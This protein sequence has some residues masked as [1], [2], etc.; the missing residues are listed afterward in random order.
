MCEFVA[1][2]D[3]LA[4]RGGRR[5]ALKRWIPTKADL[6]NWFGADHR[7]VAALWPQVRFLVALRDAESMA[8]QLDILAELKAMTSIWLSTRQ[9]FKTL[10]QHIAAQRQWARETSATRASDTERALCDLPE[11]ARA[12]LFGRTGGRDVETCMREGFVWSMTK[13]A[14]WNEL[15]ARDLPGL[16][17]EKMATLHYAYKPVGNPLWAARYV[18]RSVANKLRDA[19]DNT[20]KIPPSTRR[21]AKKRLLA[22]GARHVIERNPVAEGNQ[23]GARPWPSSTTAPR[24]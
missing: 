23:Q 20:Y 18:A 12:F 17:R 9:A 19:T 7:I 6:R 11:S 2:R 22:S 1:A 21:K 15:G 24:R 4:E 3:A 14:E 5:G 16:T 10:D 8:E 13:L